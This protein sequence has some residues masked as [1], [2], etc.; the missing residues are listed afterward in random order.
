MFS[1]ETVASNPLPAHM[2]DKYSGFPAT[3]S[4]T[5]LSG[6]SLSVKLSLN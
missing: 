1:P 4:L 6:T 3:A 5:F 2:V